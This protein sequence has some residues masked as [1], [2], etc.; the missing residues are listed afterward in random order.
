VNAGHG[1]APGCRTLAFSRPALALCSRELI[2]NSKLLLVYKKHCATVCYLYR[3][4]R[5]IYILLLISEHQRALALHAN[6]QYGTPHIDLELAG[7]PVL[8]AGWIMIMFRN[9]SI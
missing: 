3:N 6:T 7:H 1:A 2:L 5:K 8:L 9:I 4:T